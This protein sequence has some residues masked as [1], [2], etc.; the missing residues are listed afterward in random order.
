[1]KMAFNTAIWK[2]V[3]TIGTP[4]EPSDSVIMIIQRSNYLIR[5]Y[6]CHGGLLYKIM[7]LFGKLCIFKLYCRYSL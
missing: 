1:M 5:I 3:R 2:H 6:N 4:E 7:K